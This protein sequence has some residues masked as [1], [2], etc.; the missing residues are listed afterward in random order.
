MQDAA[1]LGRLIGDELLF[2]EPGLPE[3][4]K[5]AVC[6]TGHR[7]LIDAEPR[8]K[9]AR[10]DVI[11]CRRR[12]TRDNDRRAWIVDSMSKSGWSDRTVS[13]ECTSTR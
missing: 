5:A 12:L 11:V 1:A 3:W 7:V 8:R 6:G 2:V 9:H 4:A 13:S 10:D